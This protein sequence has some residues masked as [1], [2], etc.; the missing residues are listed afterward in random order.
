MVELQGEGV[1]YFHDARTLA[2]NS[3]EN[4]AAIAALGI[5]AFEYV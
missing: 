2:I 1:K 4:E 5:E 3:N